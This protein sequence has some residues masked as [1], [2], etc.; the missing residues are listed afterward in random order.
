MKIPLKAR[1]S[2]FRQRLILRMRY[3][4]RIEIDDINEHARATELRQLHEVDTAQLKTMQNIAGLL[5]QFEARLSWY[6]QN[7]PHMRQLRR[8]WDQEQSRLR[9]VD[10]ERAQA[11]QNGVLHVPPSNGKHTLDADSAAGH[12]V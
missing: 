2:L 8:Q 9:R 10:P 6:E 5:Q 3:A 7:I 1:W 12:P 4:L 11:L